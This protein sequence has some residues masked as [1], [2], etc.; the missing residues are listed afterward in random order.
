MEQI[1]DDQKLISTPVDQNR[2]SFIMHRLMSNQSVFPRFVSHDNI[3]N[4]A[5]N[6][7]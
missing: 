4:I 2:S 3:P 5:E 7:Q 6:V 1:I